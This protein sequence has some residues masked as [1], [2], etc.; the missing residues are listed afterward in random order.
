[1]WPGFCRVSTLAF[2]FLMPHRAET[3]KTRS[4]QHLERRATPVLHS[5]QL[6]HVSSRPF[7]PCSNQRRGWSA[8]RSLP[9]DSNPPEMTAVIVRPQL[10]EAE[11]Q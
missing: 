9:V 8:H 2:G 3:P 5:I 1:M 6:T 4:Q 11:R 10:R 7:P